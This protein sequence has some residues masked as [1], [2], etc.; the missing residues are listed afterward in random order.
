[1]LKIKTFA[2]N[3]LQEN[4]HILSDE[5]GETVIVDCGA[6]FNEDF[7]AIANYI[8]KNGLRPVRHLLTH[9]HFDHIFGAKWLKETY[10]LL[11]EMTET[12]TTVYKQQP[13][14]IVQFLH[15]N[16]PL[17]LPQSGT[18]F[19]AG[20]ILH[21]GSH[22]LRV[23]ATPGHTPG[24]VCFYEESE[25]VLLSGDSLFRGSIGRCDLPGGNEQDLLHSLRENILSLPSATRVFPGHGPETTIAFEAANNPYLA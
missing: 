13:Q 3:I 2:V 11:P 8:E 19:T 18:T 1:M 22:A 10:N 14:Q 17:E 5:T 9:G 16:V 24:G 6:Y 7:T 4:C 12:E 23:I 25:G 21:F 20:D 15:R